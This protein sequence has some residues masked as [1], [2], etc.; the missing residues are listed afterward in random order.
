MAT[1]EASEERVV[2]LV[3]H[4]QIEQNIATARLQRGEVASLGTPDCG[5]LC[6]GWGPGVVDVSI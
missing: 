5:T 2:Y 3:R 6:M 4:A 1:S